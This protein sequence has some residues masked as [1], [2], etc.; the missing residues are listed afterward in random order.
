M[1]DTQAINTLNELVPGWSGSGNGLLCNPNP[2]GGIIDKVMLSDEWF[3]IL[4][5]G[6][7]LDGFASR[8]EAIQAFIT[9][10]QAS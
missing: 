1:N 9:K 2:G 8:D 10:G 6:Q 4:D 5:R 3:V 7:A